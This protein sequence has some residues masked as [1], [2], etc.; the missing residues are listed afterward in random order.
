MSTYV[1]CHVGEKKNCH[2]K[3]RLTWAMRNR[4]MIIIADA[5]SG[6]TACLHYLYQLIYSCHNLKTE[7]VL[8]LFESLAPEAPNIWSNPWPSRNNPRD[9]KVRFLTLSFGLSQIF[10]N[11][12]RNHL[13]MSLVSV[14]GLRAARYFLF[15]FLINN[16]IAYQFLHLYPSN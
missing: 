16:G 8:W 9:G 4:G 3:M 6:L 12:L 5:Y 2:Q 11:C 7:Q 13:F 10:I 14:P 1:S 15:F